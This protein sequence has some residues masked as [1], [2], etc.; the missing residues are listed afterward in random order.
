[1]VKV[2]GLVAAAASMASADATKFLEMSGIASLHDG[3]CVVWEA[4]RG[5]WNENAIQGTCALGV[6]EKL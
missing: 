2:D 6:L 1:M 5:R 3:Y 4:K